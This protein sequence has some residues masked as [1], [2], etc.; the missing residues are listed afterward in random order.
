MFGRR[1]FE[2]M[3]RSA[4]LINTARGALIQDEALIAALRERLDCRG[5]D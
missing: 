1:E 5:G 4:L 3:K 2:M